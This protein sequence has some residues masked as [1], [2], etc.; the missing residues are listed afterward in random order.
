MAAWWQWLYP[1]AWRCRLVCGSR[2]RIGRGP[3]AAV[4]IYVGVL[5]P[6]LGFLNVY[7]YIFSFVADHFQYH[8]S[9]ALIALGTFSAVLWFTR[10]NSNAPPATELPVEA[11]APKRA[12]WLAQSDAP[13][14]QYW[15]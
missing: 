1:V 6:T 11:T 5:M 12:P 3:L 4:L 2:E 9:P 15:F 7:F 10:F 14:R 8:A 13:P